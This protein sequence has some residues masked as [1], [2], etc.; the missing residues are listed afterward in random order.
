[1]IQIAGS[2]AS[3]TNLTLSPSNIGV[4]SQNNA[5]ESSQDVGP[6]PTMWDAS[7]PA[8]PLCVHPLWVSRILGCSETFLS[9]EARTLI[10]VDT[11]D[12]HPVRHDKITVD[13]VRATT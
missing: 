1:M 3:S 6:G 4:L 5:V 13:T 8:E 7:R 2:Q 9:R 10:T 12:F 11:Q